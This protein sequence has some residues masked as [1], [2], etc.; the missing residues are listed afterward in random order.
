MPARRNQRRV[1][2]LLI[3]RA[4][5]DP[6]PEGEIAR[7]MLETRRAAR[8]AARSTQ[9]LPERLS[10][11]AEDIMSAWTRGVEEEFRVGHLLVEA[12]AIMPPLARNKDARGKQTTGEFSHW[13]REQRFPFSMKTAYRLRQAAEREEEV[14][15]FLAERPAGSRDMGVNTAITLMLAAPKPERERIEPA[16]PAYAA[17]RDA[18]NR[19][20]GSEDEPTNA[21]M[22]MHVD[23]LAASAKI[24][25]ALVAAYNEAKVARE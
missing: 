9:A 25:M 2:D 7:N 4:A 1:D 6:G 10:E 23:D 19:I 14:R 22:Q 21:F 3:V 20:L 16:D 5:R 13:F 11:I 8:E 17:L 24:I 15:A 12:A 18:R